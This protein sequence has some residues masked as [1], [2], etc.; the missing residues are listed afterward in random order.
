ME[1]SRTV[2]SCWQQAKSRADNED[3][4]SLPRRIR[5]SAVFTSE[6]QGK[7]GRTDG[8]QPMVRRGDAVPPRIPVGTKKV[9]GDRG[10]LNPANPVREKKR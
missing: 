1:L 9:A 5:K 7:S 6:E 8:V 10:E 3:A 4:G 2:W